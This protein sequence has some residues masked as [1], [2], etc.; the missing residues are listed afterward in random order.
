MSVNIWPPHDTLATD[1]SLRSPEANFPDV[2]MQHASLS[3]CFPLQ[4][5]HYLASTPM[6]DNLQGPSVSRQRASCYSLDN[7][8]RCLH[9]F[10]WGLSPRAFRTILKFAIG[11]AAPSSHIPLVLWKKAFSK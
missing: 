11:V 1:Q 4:M 5:V 3:F 6:H 10:P 8:D 9:P 7:M 2:T